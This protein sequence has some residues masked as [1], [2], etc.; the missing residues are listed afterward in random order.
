MRFHIHFIHFIPS[1]LCK[2]LVQLSL[3]TQANHSSHPQKRRQWVFRHA[4]GIN[5]TL[6]EC[7][8]FEA[9]QVDLN[10]IKLSIAKIA[11][12]TRKRTGT[13]GLQDNNLYFIQSD[14]LNKITSAKL[15]DSKQ[16]VSSCNYSLFCVQNWN[17]LYNT[18]RIQEQKILIT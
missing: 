14:S 9:K 13:R 18:S 7:W 15:H 4:P 1:Y 2:G 10:Y 5:T 17:N 6:I 16:K 11:R 12:T 8:L 3:L